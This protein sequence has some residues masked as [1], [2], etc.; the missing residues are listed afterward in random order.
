MQPVTIKNNQFSSTINALQLVL[1]LLSLFALVLAL[2]LSFSFFIM[3]FSVGACVCFFYNRFKALVVASLRVTD[4]GL[5]V[6]FQNYQDD[7][8]IIEEVVVR[9]YWQLPS[10][11]FLKLKTIK[12][13]KTIYLTCIRA[14]LGGEIF[15]ILLAHLIKPGKRV[16]IS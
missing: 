11:V 7:A 1:I 4:K 3:V 12:N 13:S 5:Y 8:S 14:R 2:K 6:E 10:V 9:S 15:A 16:S